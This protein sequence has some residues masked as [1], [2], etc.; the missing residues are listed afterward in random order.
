MKV[1]RIVA[2][3]LVS[4]SMALFLAC[5]EKKT[6]SLEGHEDKVAVLQ[7]LVDCLDTPETAVEIYAED[8]VLKWQDYDTAQWR[9][10]KGLKEIQKYYKDKGI[11]NHYV[12]LDISDIKEDAKS[13]HVEYQ[14]TLQ[15][16]GSG[17]EL[18]SKCSAEMVNQGQG[19][20]VKNAIS[21]R[22][23]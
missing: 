13:A 7:K 4:M 21:K 11:D 15:D 3:T 22:F 17:I 12:K 16:R 18:K 14:I 8:A 19:W 1:T 5:G 20:K 9:E 6:A 10:Q 23:E 2:I